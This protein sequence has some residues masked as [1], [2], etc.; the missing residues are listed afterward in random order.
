MCL[1]ICSALHA[2]WGMIYTA[3]GSIQLVAGIF[4]LLSLPV[5]RMGSNIATGAC[6]VL[7]GVG[8]VMLSCFGDLSQKRSE[9]LIILTFIALGINV[10]NLV[11][12]EIGEWNYFLTPKD[13]EIISSHNVEELVYYAR[14]STTFTTIAVILVAF[15]DSQLTYCSIQYQKNP[16][17]RHPHINE[18]VSD[19]EYIIPR[20]KTRSI[21]SKQSHTLN[22]YSQSWVFDAETGTSSQNDS[23]YLKMPPPSAPMEY[24]GDGNISTRRLYSSTP[25]VR[26]NV[27]VVTVQVDTTSEDG[28][29]VDRQL[30]HMRSFS[31]TPSPGGVSRS[32]S[33]SSN[34]PIYEC[35]ER[36]TQP[37]VYKSRL[38]TYK[39]A[40]DV[41]RPGSARSDYARPQSDKA[42]Y[43]SLMVEL[44]KTFVQKKVTEN[45][46]QTPP[47]EDDDNSSTRQRSSD[48]E[49]SKELEAALKLIQDLESPNTIETP[50][51]TCRMVTDDPVKCN[52]DSSKTLS[53]S[54]SF[55]GKNTK[56]LPVESQSTSGYNSPSPDRS[57]RFTPTTGIS[58]D[59]LSETN[60]S[61]VIRHL[62]DTAV[63]SL[64]SSKEP[65]SSLSDGK[66][67]EFKMV[68]S[69]KI[70]VNKVNV[71][72]EF[73]NSKK[74]KSM[75]EL[76]T[77]NFDE[78]SSTRSKLRKWKHF[79]ERNKRRPS[80]LPEVE[81]AIV[82]S[83]CL[84]FLT[85]S[86]LKDRLNHFKNVHRQIETKVQREMSIRKA[87][88]FGSIEDIIDSFSLS[89]R[90]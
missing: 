78:G 65:H 19:I 56:T 54:S 47:T 57:T 25:V 44:E 10:I 29:E 69:D 31:R 70:F 63:I 60:L 55:N 26:D 45:P 73:I 34:L 2:L 58:S 9:K 84:A 22:Q 32:S 27:G 83:E 75:I 82:K 16:N 53:G 74:T 20:H 24:D 13:R 28:T 15:L 79:I 85:D 90:L 86:E 72:E 77:K 33:S 68:P 51:E 67:T 35:L 4:F 80:L 8:T 61:C 37:N 41:S 1:K 36:L 5:F 14:V 38:D 89:T 7:I 52:S 66:S 49:F 64:F 62:G 87:E 3:A 71:N 17:I 42:Q 30:N 21:S 43:A 50:S 12:L 59:D 48:A 11:V 88:S 81:S 23:P 40:N 76:K 39:T 46:L 18:T 6:N